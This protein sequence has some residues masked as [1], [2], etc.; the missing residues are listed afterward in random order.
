[1]GAL[2]LLGMAVIVCGVVV[3]TLTRRKASKA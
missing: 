3:I 1:V 2:D